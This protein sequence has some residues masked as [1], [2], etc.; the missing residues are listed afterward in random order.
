MPAAPL[1]DFNDPKYAFC[2]N[3]S[4][5]CYDKIQLSLPGAEK[6]TDILNRRMYAILQDW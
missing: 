6:L 2:P 4:S 5:N 3:D 1:I